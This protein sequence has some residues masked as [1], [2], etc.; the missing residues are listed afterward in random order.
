MI[1]QGLRGRRA[2]TLIELLVV[3]AIIAILIALLVPAVQK[4]REAASRTQC[5]NNLKQ[6]ALACHGYH[7]AHKHL[8]PGANVRSGASDMFDTWEW[9]ETGFVHLLPYVEEEPL[10]KMYDFSIGP[11]GVDGAP[12]GGTNP[13][14]AVKQV[15]VVFV[16]PTDIPAHTFKKQSPRDGHTDAP[17]SGPSPLSSYCFN[18]GRQWGA[19]YDNFFARSLA[20]RDLTKVGPF[21]AA[22]RTRLTDITDGTSNTFLA[23]ETAQDDTATPDTTTILT[24]NWNETSFAPILNNGRVHSMWIEADHHCMRSTER[25]AFRSIKD[26]V[27]AGNH[28]KSCRYFFGGQHTGGTNMALAD[29]SIRLV[30]TGVSLTAVWQPLGTMNGGET[31]PG[32]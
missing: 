1:R 20:K 21:S 30:S 31:I 8:P 27:D 13:Q 24:Y 11:G 28:P 14:N 15:V 12:A 22:S 23:G 16:C 10:Y 3:I 32:F 25:E 7:D 29:G 26:C 17:D 6:I 2:F 5:Q 4:V 19:S 18:T 9:R